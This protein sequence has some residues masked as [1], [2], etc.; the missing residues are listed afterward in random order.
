M[1]EQIESPAAARYVTY[2]P[3][4]A[5][6]GCYL[7]APA[8]EHVDRM[9][10]IDEAQAEGWVNYRAN[11]V[12]DGLEMLPAAEPSAPTEAQA[13]S[14]Y[15]AAVQQHM[16]A[17]AVLY[18]YDNLISVI[19]YAEEPAVARYQAEGQAFRAWRSGCWFACEQM[20]AAVQAGERPA[21]SHAE[22]I[23]ELPVLSLSAPAALAT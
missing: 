23:A 14:D 7:Q 8:A 12:R 17:R 4:G 18:G 1:D 21:P 19:T 20:L 9:I 5:L 10:V 22:L 2:L 16:D 15:M 3:D 6:D 13:V 11:E